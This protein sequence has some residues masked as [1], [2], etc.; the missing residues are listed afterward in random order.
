M[1]LFLT[2][3]QKR[4]IAYLCQCKIHIKS[5]GLEICGIKFHIAENAL[6]EIWTSDMKLPMG[7][8]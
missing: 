4:S 5:H 6:V 1:K 3:K 7:I 2:I 8:Q